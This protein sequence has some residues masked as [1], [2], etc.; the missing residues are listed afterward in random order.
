MRVYT[1][2]GKNEYYKGKYTQGTL[3]EEDDKPE[4]W[5]R[6]GTKGRR[7]IMGG[8][9]KKNLPRGWSIKNTERFRRDKAGLAME[10]RVAIRMEYQD[11]EE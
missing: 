9:E 1:K 3:V 2:A 5:G 10:A 8:G 6:V 7:V 11:S 4:D